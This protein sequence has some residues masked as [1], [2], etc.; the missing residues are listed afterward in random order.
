FRN[1]CRKIFLIE[2]EVNQSNSTDNYIIGIFNT[3][4]IYTIFAASWDFLAGFVGQISFGHSIFFGVAGYVTA[5]TTRYGFPWISVDISVFPWDW[6]VTFIVI[7]W[8]PALVLGAIV[9][10]IFGLIIGVPALRLKGPYLALGTLSMSLILYQLLLMANLG[11]MWEQIFPGTE[12]FGTDG[13][14]QVPPI[15]RN[16]IIQY[17]IIFLILCTSLILLTHLVK[18]KLGT[19]FKAIRDDET[20]AKSSGINTTRYKIL[21]FMISGFFAGVAGGI[22]ALRFSGV[23]PGVFQP[24]YSFYAIIIAAI[25]GIASIS[26]AA[27]GAFFFVFLSEILRLLGDNPQLTLATGGFIEPIFIFSIILIVMIRFAEHGIM[28]PA[29]ERIQ[30]LWDILLGR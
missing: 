23:N 26:G 13:I 27:L 17:L 22:F 7:S 4:M 29:L 15:S 19:I 24:L 1:I 6:D 21:A 28:K 10:V 18:S 5:F 11:I 3:F 8:L 12:L 25:G 2:F 30:D 16:P 20:G 14:G 9:A